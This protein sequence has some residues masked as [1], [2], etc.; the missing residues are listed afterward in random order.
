MIRG[1]RFRGISR[2]T[3]QPPHL[4][5]HGK[6]Q[7]NVYARM[8]IG[9]NI[10]DNDAQNARV[11]VMPVARMSATTIRAEPQA[12]ARSHRVLVLLG[13]FWKV[14]QQNAKHSAVNSGTWV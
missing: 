14:M 9:A 11:I 12:G 6:A 8:R 2:S 4:C 5:H 7:T 3:K 13:V 1:L 10:S